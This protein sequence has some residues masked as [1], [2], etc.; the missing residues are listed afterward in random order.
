M[1]SQNYDKMP[2]NELKKIY[3]EE[4]EKA[5]K[6]IINKIKNL[7]MDEEGK[8]TFVRNYIFYSAIDYKILKYIDD[9][10]E[11]MIE[12]D[13][14]NTDLLEKGDTKIELKEEGDL[15]K[16]VFKLLSAKI[17]VKEAVP[18]GVPDIHALF[19]HM[20]CLS[21]TAHY[22]LGKEFFDRIEVIRFGQKP[23]V[24]QKK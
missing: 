20:N 10:I 24:R 23:K 11:F 5:K 13:G 9:N 8:Y 1:S 12:L 3:K 19:K 14:G 22:D 18:Y 15:I 21:L 17:K 2:L 6:K 16:K 7:K 4:K